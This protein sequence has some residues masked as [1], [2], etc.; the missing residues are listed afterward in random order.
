MGLILMLTWSN[1]ASNV[2]HTASGNTK[3]LY[4]NVPQV[5]R[6]PKLP[7]SFPDM[8]CNNFYSAILTGRSNV[9]LASHVT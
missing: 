1:I 3:Q 8:F 5:I 9:F 7:D 6:N 4:A 2:I